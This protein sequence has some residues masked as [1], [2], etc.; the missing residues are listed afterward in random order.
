MATPR[1]TARTS[2]TRKGKEAQYGRTREKSPKYPDDS[3]DSEDPGHPNPDS[4]VVHGKVQRVDG[5][6]V[7]DVLVK[8]VD[9]DIRSEERL[10]LAK[11]TREGTYRI[12]Y[13][14]DQ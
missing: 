1:A 8:A 5:S 4:F 12:P 9:V 3:N 14:R 6:V 13:T 11:T 7:T 2:P 10:G